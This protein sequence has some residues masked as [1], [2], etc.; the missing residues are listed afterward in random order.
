[1]HTRKEKKKRL[2]GVARQRPSTSRG[3]GSTQRQDRK[4][5]TKQQGAKKEKKRGG[6]GENGLKLSKKTEIG[7]RGQRPSQER[8]VAI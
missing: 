1:M 5:R 4:K 8:Q 3:L 6:T 2:E 7:D